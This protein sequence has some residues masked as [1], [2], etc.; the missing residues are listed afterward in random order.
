MKITKIKKGLYDR[1]VDS[2]AIKCPLCN[3][4]TVLDKAY[5]KE[6]THLKETQELKDKM[7]A[8]KAANL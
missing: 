2:D 1:F 8:Q 6:L 7:R 3:E 4:I 5:T